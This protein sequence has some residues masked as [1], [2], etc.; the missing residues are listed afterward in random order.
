MLKNTPIAR[1]EGLLGRIS[2]FGFNNLPNI[3]C[4]AEKVRRDIDYKAVI[5]KILYKS[6][7]GREKKILDVWM[8]EVDKLT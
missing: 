7:V 2:K 1:Q 8:K 6:L 4:Y 3:I 5:R